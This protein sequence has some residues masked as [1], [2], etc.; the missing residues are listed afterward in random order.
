M[1][2]HFSV[3]FISYINNG[4]LLYLCFSGSTGSSG[5]RGVRGLRRPF[6]ADRDRDSPHE[7][8][9]ARN[10]PVQFL[11]DNA[12]M[13]P[14]VPVAQQRHRPRKLFVS[15][16]CRCIMSE[17]S[18]WFHHLKHT[19]TVPTISHSELHQFC[20]LITIINQRN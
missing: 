14:V 5:G 10:S 11:G 20:I 12:V 15:V 3:H 1:T 4:V 9:H 18:L 13:G 6:G 8:E 17:F 2:A 16:L 19:I 7:T